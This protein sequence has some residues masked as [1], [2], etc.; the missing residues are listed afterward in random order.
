MMQARATIDTTH[1]QEVVD[2]AE[3]PD[4]PVPLSE[5]GGQE[6]AIQEFKN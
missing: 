3:Q 2:I 1:A 6:E 5:V 4:D